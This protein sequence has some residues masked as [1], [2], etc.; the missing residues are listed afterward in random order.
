MADTEKKW[1]VLR[2]VSGKEAKVKEYIEAELKHNEKLASC[3]SQVLLPVEKHASLRNG[4]RVVKEKISDPNTRTSV[5]KTVSTTTYAAGTKPD[6]YTDTS[7]EPRDDG[8]S[9]TT[10]KYTYD[11][12]KNLKKKVSNNTF[13]ETDETSYAWTYTS[14]TPV[15]TD[16]AWTSDGT[17]TKTILGQIT[18]SH[19]TKGTTTYD[20]T[21]NE[22]TGAV[23]KAYVAKGNALESGEKDASTDVTKATYSVKKKK[24]PSAYAEQAEAQQWAI[25]NGGDLNSVLTQ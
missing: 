6:I 19:K 14:S 1:Y 9:T 24:V 21:V 5:T 15:E 2:A 18:L 11:K 4:K 17:S 16:T 10:V 3:V 25:T 12:N 8:K 7:T 20:V 23:K 22:K 13:I